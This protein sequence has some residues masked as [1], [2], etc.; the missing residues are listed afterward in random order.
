MTFDDI[1]DILQHGT[2]IV[3]YVIAIGS[4]LSALTPPPLK[5]DEQA[6]S[7]GGKIRKTKIYNFWYRIVS[8]CAAN[9]GWAKN[10]SSPKV[11]TVVTEILKG[12]S[13][14]QAVNDLANVAEEEVKKKESINKK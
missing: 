6:S 4:L 1:S 12:V 2:S 13:N 10:I 7:I 14:K 3:V 8:F 5:K 11:M 9:I